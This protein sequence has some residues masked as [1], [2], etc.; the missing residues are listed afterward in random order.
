MNQKKKPARNC[1]SKRAKRKTKSSFYL[2]LNKLYNLSPSKPTLADLNDF[3][4]NGIH[5]HIY[6]LAHFCKQRGASQAEAEELIEEKTRERLPRRTVFLNEISRQVASAYNS[7]NIVTQVPRNKLRSLE[8]SSSNAY[9]NKHF[10]TLS[11]QLFDLYKLNYVKKNYTWNVSQMIEESPMYWPHPKPCGSPLTSYATISSLYIANDIIAC[12]YK[13]IKADGSVGYPFK[14]KKR[15]D[16]IADQSMHE[17]IVPNPMRKYKGINQNGNLSDR[18]RDNAGLRKYLVLDF[19]QPTMTH[20]C[21]ASVIKF[22]KEEIR[23]LVMVMFSGN[24]SLHAW[25]QAYDDEYSNHQ[26]FKT[27]VTLGADPALEKPEQPARTPNAIRVDTGRKQEVY[28][29]NP[30]KEGMHPDEY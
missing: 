15:I 2:N 12:G 7:R 23:P 30:K 21:M 25:F 27:A 29:F 13:N 11:N 24:K 3:P 5:Q 18:T 26:F 8:K 1:S 19:D 4:L 14:G 16:W 10:P 28:W 17:L 22:F 20:A 6:A 9:W